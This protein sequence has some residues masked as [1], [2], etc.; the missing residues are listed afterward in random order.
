VSDKHLGCY[1]PPP[2][3]ESRPKIRNGRSFKE[4]RH[5]I[6]FP[7]F[8]IAFSY[9]AST[10]VN[11]L[12]KG[13]FWYLLFMVKFVWRTSFIDFHEA[14]LLWE[15]SKIAHTAFSVYGDHLVHEWT[16]HKYLA[17]SHEHNIGHMNLTL[18]QNFQK[19]TCWNGSM[20]TRFWKAA[21]YQNGLSTTFQKGEIID[22]KYTLRP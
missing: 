1:S 19:Y 8:A 17:L 3:K 16:T 10:S 7:T 21:L 5:V 13:T 9:K 22:D 20:F 14:L 4:E 12:A 18:D 2:L 6:K 15:E 11:N